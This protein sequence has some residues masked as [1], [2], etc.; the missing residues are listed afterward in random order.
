MTRRQS[1]AEVR[2]S[3]LGGR[4]ARCGFTLVE[5]LTV[6]AIIAIILSIVLVAAMDSMRR[7]QERATEALITKLDQG[8][9]DRLEAL[10]QTR[11]DYTAVHLAMANIY[12]TTDPN[13]IQSI[14]RAQVIAW[15]D[16]V[17]AQVPDVFFVQN[18]NP[19]ASDYPLNFA[20]N[21]LLLPATL[22]PF[23]INP[24]LLP[25][26]SLRADQATIAT[27]T[28]PVATG[29]Y[30]AAYTAAAGVY[31]NLGYLPAG[32]DGVD[33]DADGFVDNYNEGVCQAPNWTAPDPTT[34]AL[35]NG[36]LHSHIHS[37]ARSEMLYALLVE[38]TGPLGSVFSPDE[39][40][41]R[42]VKDTDG[43]GLPEFVDAWGQPLQFFRWPL[44][45]RSDIQRGQRVTA[46]GG[47]SWT[48]MNQTPYLTVFE[49]REQDPLD[50]NQQLMAP[51]WWTQAVNAKP[52]I[53]LST[54]ASYGSI[55]PAPLPSGAMQSFEY[56]F[57]RL[58]EPLPNAG[59][60]LYWD[61][62]VPSSRRAF[63]SKFLIVSGGPDQ[64]VGIF[65]YPD[66]APPTPP[67]TATQLIANE[68]NAMPFGLDV[69]D[70]TV[71]AVIQNLSIPVNAASPSS[72]NPNAPTSFDL[73]QFAQDDISNQNLQG[74]GVIGGSG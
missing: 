70:F 56:F 59:G 49:N 11:P 9:S 44:L 45:Y 74:T 23:P 16:Y 54:G 15:C 48:L 50:L 12:T 69:A 14:S 17:K 62:T 63:Y 46:T 51:G 19:A 10:L 32:Y 38:G 37:T 2:P 41:D 61:R 55:A 29:I 3:L 68:N 47:E 21:Q 57:H 58:S 6:V 22:F 40:T 34:V 20:G 18:F 8:L 26:G 60:P 36:H 71:N 33:N 30:G 66:T 27:P 52:A 43:D 73:Q 31:K 24:V 42:E 64:S 5:L 13:P 4:A 35:V 65:R 25:L 39:F 7:A 28:N 67:A 1:P 53:S 72:G